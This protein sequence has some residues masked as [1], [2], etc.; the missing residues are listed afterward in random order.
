MKNKY[1]GDEVIYSLVIFLFIVLIYL[2]FT[3]PAHS[4]N[5]AFC[6]VGEHPAYREGAMHCV[7]NPPKMDK[8]QWSLIAADAGVRGLDAYSTHWALSHNNVEDYLPSGLAEN[9]AAMWVYSES[10]VAINGFVS[11][12]LVRHHHPRWAKVVQCVD[13]G[14]DLPMGIHNLNLRELPPHQILHLG[15]Q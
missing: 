3:Q 11:W 14:Y 6:A 4:Q 7:P 8:I 5:F 15:E 12:E 1:N 10:I 2:F 9:N 13:I